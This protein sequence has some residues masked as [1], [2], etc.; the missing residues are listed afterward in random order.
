MNTIS[1]ENNKEHMGNL[2][3]ILFVTLERKMAWNLEIV[4]KTQITSENCSKKYCSHF[5]CMNQCFLIL[6]GK[7]KNH[8][9]FYG[10]VNE[11]CIF[12]GNNNKITV[13][14]SKISLISNNENSRNL[15]KI[16]FDIDE[17]MDFLFQNSLIFN[18]MNCE[19]CNVNMVLKMFMDRS[20]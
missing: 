5:K 3:L 2:L 10:K 14:N 20:E 11:Y 13:Y 15:E 6:P 7:V 18:E 17:F 1:T 4:H 12:I 16:T 8:C 19:Q 9:N